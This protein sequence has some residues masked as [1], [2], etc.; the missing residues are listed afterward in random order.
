MGRMDRVIEAGGNTVK[1]DSMMKM[2]AKIFNSEGFMK[3]M[4][5]SIENLVSK[6]P[7]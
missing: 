6:V 2:H 1:R 3:K 4:M 5:G 7:K